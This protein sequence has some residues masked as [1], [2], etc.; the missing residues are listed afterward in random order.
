MSQRF[1]QAMVDMWSVT[2][3]GKMGLKVDEDYK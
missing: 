3:I 2:K 1:P